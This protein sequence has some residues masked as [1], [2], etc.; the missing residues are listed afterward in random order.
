[1]LAVATVWTSLYRL[2]MWGYKA[3]H[4][5]FISWVFVPSGFKLFVSLILRFNSIPGLILG[6]LYLNHLYHPELRVHDQVILSLISSVTGLVACLIMEGILKKKL[7][8]YVLSVQ[9][10][11]SLSLIYALSNSV[12]HII[13]F[14]LH[15][16][17]ISVRLIEPVKM[18]V[19][20]FFGVA[21]FMAIIN[22]MHY[23]YKKYRY[24][25]SQ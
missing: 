17:L 19:G 6:S 10:F 1:M 24:N 12:I 14:N 13:F 20:D 21:I 18:F 4:M 5:P 9:E 7:L 3:N 15:H 16:D 23:L 8:S 25:V 2:N 11:I 22:R